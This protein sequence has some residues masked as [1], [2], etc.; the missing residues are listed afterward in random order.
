MFQEHY[1]ITFNK[2][3][4]QVT[5]VLVDTQITAEFNKCTGIEIE[6]MYSKLVL[7]WNCL[8][9]PDDVIFHFLL[10]ISVQQ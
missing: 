1:R 10:G 9:T 5:T 3:G 8:Y 7:A 6:K 2:C 4:S